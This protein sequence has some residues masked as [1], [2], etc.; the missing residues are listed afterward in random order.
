MKDIEPQPGQ[1]DNGQ[2]NPGITDL[3]GELEHLMTV[4]DPTQQRPGDDLAERT[5]D[6]S[7]TRA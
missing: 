7:D 3:L 2:N 1:P 4:L 5:K 6:T